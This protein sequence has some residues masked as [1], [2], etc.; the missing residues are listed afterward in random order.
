[1]QAGLVRERARADVGLPAVRRH[2][3][4]LADGVRQPG[5]VAEPLG[6]DDL[7]AGLELEVRDDGEDVGVAGAL[8]VAVH[9]ALDVARAGLD[10]RQRVG[11]GAAGVV[12]AVDAEPGAR[13]R[14][15][16]GDDVLHLRRQHPAVGVAEG[17]DLGAG[18]G[19]DPDR[20]ERVGAVRRIP[21]EEVLGVEEHPAPLAVQEAHGVADHR[22]VLLAGRPQRLL[23][24]PDV[25][26]RDEGDDG[27]PGGQQRADQRVVG[28]LRP[29]PAGGAER[30]QRRVLQDQL[31]LRA[32][33][34]L[35][36]LGVR[37]GP[38]ALDEPHAELVEVP[39]D[40]ELVDD[41]EVEPLLLGAVAQ[42]RVVDVQVARRSAGGVG[43]RRFPEAGGCRA[44]VCRPLLDARVRTGCARDTKRPPG[45][46]EVCA[47]RSTRRAN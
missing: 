37:P 3:G 24:V 8:A 40:G 1:M 15:D 4:H 45:L 31:V 17:D 42:R 29:G 34:E 38:A 35:G 2:V 39:R 36:V 7:V 13:R 44:A 32:L 11:D 25:R 14:E 23:D 21:V 16:V 46:R 30:G 43:H 33:E 20:L 26:L 28:G 6:R 5:R 12:V 27:R 10:R 18:L 9:G 41:R 19:R 47:T 22:E